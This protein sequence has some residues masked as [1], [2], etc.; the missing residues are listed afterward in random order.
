MIKMVKGGVQASASRT[1]FDKVW[2]KKGWTLVNEGTSVPVPPEAH[3]GWTD[4]ET[5]NSDIESL[6]QTDATEEN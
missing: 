6:N 3:R 4:R 5:G 2:S 1:A